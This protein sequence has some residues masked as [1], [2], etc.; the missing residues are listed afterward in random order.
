MESIGASVG[1]VRD[2]TTIHPVE[3]SGESD[4]RESKS[5]DDDCSS[6]MEQGDIIKLRE[7][8]K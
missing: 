3:T 4:S 1:G 2:S 7:K 8:A 6:V 5:E